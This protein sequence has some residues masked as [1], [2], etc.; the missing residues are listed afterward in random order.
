MKNFIYL[1][2]FAMGFIA[3]EKE[4]LPEPM[5]AEHGVFVLNQG[6]QRQN[7]A[8]L[9]TYNPDSSKT[10]TVIPLIGDLGQDMLI[11]GNKLYIAVTGSS[12]IHVLDITTKQDVK[13]SLS[14]TGS[15]KPY[16]PRYLAAHN[17]K[18]YATCYNGGQG[19]VW[20]IDTVSLSLEAYTS[21]GSYP[22]GIAVNGEKLYI[23]NSGQGY[24][25]TVS[26][27]DIAT[28]K[29][30]EKITVGMNPNI[31]QADGNYIYLSYQGISW[32]GVRVPG[33]FQRID[34]RNNSIVT[35]GESPKTDFAIVNGS[36]YYYD[37]T[38]NPDWSTVV[39]FGKMTVAADGSKTVSPLIK[40]D[41]S[42]I[43][44][45]GIAVHPETGDIYIADAGDYT[46]PGCVYVFDSQGKKL[47]KFTVGIV[48]C[49]FVFY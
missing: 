29:E 48:P 20:K 40:D 5:P 33:G 36:I 9:W 35:V 47:D 34:V 27:V 13:I 26:I 32:E 15:N 41:V 49:K 30:S 44:P 23:A 18:I 43:S 6:T 7:N 45:Y 21:V 12:V 22:E 28:F 19:I 46:N 10:S 39:T 1:A 31:V 38:Y 3:C 42:I 14:E 8:S 24:A 17:G 25:N 4:S 11:Y 37:I 2:L 16:E